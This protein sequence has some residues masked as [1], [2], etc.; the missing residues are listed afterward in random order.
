[1]KTE[2]KDDLIVGDMMLLVKERG[3][4]PE[5]V[6]IDRLTKTQ[7]VIRLSGTETWR[8]KRT[9]A[10]S[11]QGEPNG[12]HEPVSRIWPMGSADL[13]DFSDEAAE[14]LDK[15]HEVHKQ[16]VATK[17]AEREHRENE[18]EE[19]HQRELA[20][21]KEAVGKKLAFKMGEGKADGS[22]LYVFDLPINPQNADRKK[23]W[24]TVIV[25]CWDAKRWDF[26]GGVVDA[27]EYAMTYCNGSNGSFGSISTSYTKTDEE[28]L[29][30]AARRQYHSW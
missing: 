6:N 16:H 27:V 9:T 11:S 17:K 13:F 15:K 22:R 8:F 10:W 21:V 24:E 29:W 12:R 5:T 7:I 26:G 30:E 28:A 19:R 14:L 18:A 4:A 2:V 20:E 3:A 25:H 1:M 23:G